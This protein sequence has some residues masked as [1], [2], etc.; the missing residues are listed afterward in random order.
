MWEF[1]GGKVEA[2]ETDEEALTREIYEELSE[3]ITV[4]NHFLSS[5]I[6]TLSK[7]LELHSYFVSGVNVSVTKGDSHSEIK[8]LPVE[9]LRSINWAPADIPIVE[10]LIHEGLP[11]VEIN[12]F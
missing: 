12:V 8:W 1:P 5:K 4:Q 6:Q 7:A 10:K 11:K 9:E 3:T 2:G